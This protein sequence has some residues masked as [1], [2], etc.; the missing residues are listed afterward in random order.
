[1]V[2]THLLDEKV[3]DWMYLQVACEIRG[4]NRYCSHRKPSHWHFRSTKNVRPRII[5]EIYQRAADII[6][7]T[8][9]AYSI[10]RKDFDKFATGLSLLF[11]F[12][13]SASSRD[14]KMELYPKDLILHGFR[15]YQMKKEDWEA[16]RPYLRKLL[17]D[18]TEPVEKKGGVVV[19]EALVQ[20]SEV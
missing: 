14:I 19:I 5:L 1:M 11:G 8:Y 17:V 4:H 13:L 18:V 9:P 7:R 16:F 6:A 12:P 10:S 2:Y 3:L 20:K 15:R